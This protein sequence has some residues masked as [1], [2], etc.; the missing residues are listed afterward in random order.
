MPTL[1]E[2]MSDGA[3]PA[4]RAVLGI[5]SRFS[6]EESYQDGN[7]QASI[8]VARWE[9]C[10]EQGYVLMLSTKDYSK[11]LNIAFFEHRNSDQICAI[12]WEQRTMN[13]PT[14]ETAEFGGQCYEDKWDTSHEV[15]Y[16][17][18]YKMAEWI[19]E[20]LTVFWLSNNSKRVA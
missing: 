6:I 17:E 1:N 11:Q 19:E 15:K 20:E 12:K 9:N 7:Y 13:A 5:M 18:H 8:E 14:I 4:A 2:Y 10:R 16:N 3:C